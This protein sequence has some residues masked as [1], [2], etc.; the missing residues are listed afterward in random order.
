MHCEQ[1]S[2]EIDDLKKAMQDIEY[3]V[4][5]D[6]QVHD[7]KRSLKS[8]QNKPKPQPN[9]PSLLIKALVQSKLLEQQTK[10]NLRKQLQTEVYLRQ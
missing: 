9:K 3:V 8:S 1:M 10:S 6:N 2:K 4:Q 7:S 5:N